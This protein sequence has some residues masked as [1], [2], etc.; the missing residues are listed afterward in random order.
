MKRQTPV[1]LKYIILLFTL[2]GVMYSSFSQM[3][4]DTTRI[5]FRDKQMIFIGKAKDTSNN[6]YRNMLNRVEAHWAGIEL[7]P[8]MLMNG[9]FGTTFP[10]AKHWENDPGRSFSWNFN[11]AEYKIKLY[12]NFVGVTTGLGINW[13]QI[14]LKNNI[15]QSNS[16]S[17]WVFQDSVN[18]YKRNKLRAVYIQVPLLL[19]FCT[20][21]KSDRGFYFSVGVV[22]GVKFG[23]STIQLLEYD[24]MKNRTKT[25]GS[26]G[27]NPFKLDAAFRVGYRRVGLFANYAMMP[28]F[29]KNKTVGVYPLTIG[30]TLN[31]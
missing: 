21:K 25:K 17:V 9:S 24:K 26:Y 8:T 12:H 1:R 13:T 18:D 22:G 3:D 19:E 7:G 11:F 29:D 30:L 27:L 31:L 15:L 2:F 10:G 23:S 14:G 5:R 16:D 20:R 28:L 6:S 4:Y